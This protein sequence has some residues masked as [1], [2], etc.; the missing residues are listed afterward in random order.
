M[1]QELSQTQSEFTSGVYCIYSS[2]RSF[3]SPQTFKRRRNQLKSVDR[4]AVGETFY[5]DREDKYSM[6]SKRNKRKATQ[7]FHQSQLPKRS[8]ISR[9]LKSNYQDIHRQAERIT[10][11]QRP[12][13][14]ALVIGRY[15]HIPLDPGIS[16][17]YY[18][19][20]PSFRHYK[21]INEQMLEIPTQIHSSITSRSP[22]K[23]RMTASGIPRMVE[24]SK[25]RYSVEDIQLNFM[26]EKAN[27][28]RESMKSNLSQ[29][30]HRAKNQS[31]YDTA[32]IPESE[33]STNVF[34]KV[35]SNLQNSRIEVSMNYFYLNYEYYI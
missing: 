3:N 22:K 21:E 29:L 14:E 30:L 17:D 4:L 2:F 16:K 33:I 19:E 6:T 23:N 7:R 11:G 13:S 20:E 35:L 9:L 5:I 32:K 24:Y 18:K 15:S 28:T 31:L 12:T 25:L 27:Q 1:R 8:Q 34:G 26:N 10:L